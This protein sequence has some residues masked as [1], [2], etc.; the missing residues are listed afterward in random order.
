M[1]IELEADIPRSKQQRVER[2]TK[3]LFQ[4]AQ[5]A[6]SRAAQVRG[7]GYPILRRLLR[8]YH[9]RTS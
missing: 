6:L 3:D 4:H 8:L 2:R 5:A 7:I 1:Q 9:E